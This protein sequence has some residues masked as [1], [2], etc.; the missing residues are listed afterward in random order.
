MSRGTTIKFKVD[1]EGA[2]LA[3]LTFSE[4]TAFVHALGAAVKAFDP[5]VDVDRIVPVRL[6]EGSHC[7]DLHA[8]APLAKF[9]RGLTEN[10]RRWTQVHAR[11]LR[12]LRTFAA[13]RE[14]TI[15]A[16]TSRGKFR[17][18]VFPDADRAG[19]IGGSSYRNVSRALAFLERS[20]GAEPSAQLLFPNGER[21]HPRV[22][23]RELAEKLARLTYRN[24]FV[25]LDSRHDADTGDVLE[26]TVVDFEAYEHR[27][28]DG[29]VEAGAFA[30]TAEHKSVAEFLAERSPP[31]G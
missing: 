6:S 31:H 27:T 21:G 25:T 19:F 4:L 20:G 17:P 7:Y 12:P 29:L 9:V 22:S 15:S 30:F 14:A 5:S 16:A 24:V 2:K 11:S 10:R 8:P 18:I 23:S 26:Q 3:T 1:Y 28:L 13:E